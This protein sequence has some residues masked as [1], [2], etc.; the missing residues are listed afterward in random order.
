MGIQTTA[1]VVIKIGS[2][3]ATLDKAGYLAVTDSEAIGEVTDIGA[4]GKMFNTA[5]H[6][7]MATRGIIEK[8]TSFNYQHPALALAID[9]ANAG[10]AACDAAVETDDSYTIT[11]IKQN[12]DAIFFT[13]QVKGFTVTFATDAFENGSIDLLTQSDR[14]KATAA[15]VAA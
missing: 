12:G 9:E 5:T 11:I 2:A 14:V 6:N 4:V 8:K 13:A 3:P 15:E 7:P 10:Q 1:G